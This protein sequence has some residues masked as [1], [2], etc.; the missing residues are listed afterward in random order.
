MIANAIPSIVQSPAASPSTPSEKLTTFISPTSQIALSTP[1]A[2]GN[3]SAPMNGSVTSVTITPPSTAITAAA[4][5]PSSFTS[6]GRSRQSSIAPTSVI[7][8]APAMIAHVW[9]VP[10]DPRRVADMRQVDRRRHPDRRGD[11][12]AGQD[13]QPAEQRR[14]PFC[15]SP[16]SLGIVDRADPPREPRRE[17][18]QQRR[19]GHR[20]EEGEDGV[21]VP[22]RGHRMAARRTAARTGPSDRGANSDRLL[23]D[24]ARRQS[25][26]ATTGPPSV[27]RTAGSARRSRRR[28]R[29]ARPARPRSRAGLR[30]PRR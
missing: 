18:R 4:I 17:R 23:D 27:P 22:H 25:R 28:A 20:D 14:R 2:F 29:S 6:G 10:P 1:P 21:P 24:R 15:D 13:R 12:H 9:T 26:T 5:C 7:R 11:Q 30:A 19:D 16:R 3:W 8:A